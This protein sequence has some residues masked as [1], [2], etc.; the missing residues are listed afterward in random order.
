M[1][2]CYIKYS[3]NLN[4]ISIDKLTMV[5]QACD[6]MNDTPFRILPFRNKEIVVLPTVFT[7]DTNATLL[8]E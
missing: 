8:S 3:T 1:V 4:L 7:P 5:A 2:N 6:Y